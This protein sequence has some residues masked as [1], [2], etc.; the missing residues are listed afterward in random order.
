M[1]AMH[2][3]SR[4]APLLLALTLLPAALPAQDLPP[5]R[6]VKKSP[7]PES[8][9]T[10]ASPRDKGTPKGGKGDGG[11]K[12]T[13][14]QVAV[15]FR[16]DED[17]RLTIDDETTLDLKGGEGRKLPLAPG[18]HLVAARAADGTRSW[19]E[20]VEV[21]G[22]GQLVVRIDFRSSPSVFLTPEEFDRRAGEM[23]IAFADLEKAAEALDL[24]LRKSFGFLDATLSTN[25]YVAQQEIRRRLED[26]RFLESRDPKR[27]A[28][29]DDIRRAQKSADLFVELSAKAL[30]AAQNKNGWQGEPNDLYSQA[31]A[32]LPSARWNSET[33]A[34]L[35][36]SAPFLAAL[37]A[38]VKRRF[39]IP[40]A[41]GDFDL[42][43]ESLSAEPRRVLLVRPKSAAAEA[44]FE[45]GDLLTKVAGEAA[46]SL[47]DLARRLAKPGAVV[48]VT[49]EREGKAKSLRVRGGAA[50][51]P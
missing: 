43:A 23:A 25:L 5:P 34:L 12:A 14:G 51:R 44:G 49:V 35:G 3:R 26:P 7:P 42:G 21:K 27:R 9:G 46:V 19:E 1:G 48:E 15:L 37:P 22:G 32:R 29:A 30:V 13:G 10:A 38:D 36:G 28:A 24:K 11:E 8:G 17:C 39:R 20:T 6:P 2:L 47:D 40:L 33:F 50:P 45:P 41:A 16:A 4:F 18:Q 31:I